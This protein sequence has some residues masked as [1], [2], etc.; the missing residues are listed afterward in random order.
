MHSRRYP[1]TTVTWSLTEAMR[2]PIFAR[3]ALPLQ[4]TVRMDTIAC[5]FPAIVRFPPNSVRYRRHD[6]DTISA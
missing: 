3:D 4:Q 2:A 6:N 5:V 1:L